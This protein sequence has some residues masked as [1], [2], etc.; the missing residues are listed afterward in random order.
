MLTWR[1]HTRH[2]HGHGRCA[3]A[4]MCVCAC[5]CVLCMHLRMCMRH[6]RM[7]KRRVRMCMCMSM[8]RLPSGSEHE[9][10]AAS[11]C[12]PWPY[13]LEMRASSGAYTRG[14]PASLAAIRAALVLPVPG[15]P[16]KRRAGRCR[17]A[18]RSPPSALVP[19]S[20]AANASGWRSGRMIASSTMP[21]T[22]S[23]PASSSQ[24]APPS[25]G[26]ASFGGGGRVTLAPS[27]CSISSVSASSWG[28]GAANQPAVACAAATG[29]EARLP[30]PRRRLPS[31]P[32]STPPSTLL[33]ADETWDE[34]R[35]EPPAGMPLYPL[36]ESGE[37]GCVH[38]AAFA[39]E[40]RSAASVAQ[41]FL[42]PT[43]SLPTLPACPTCAGFGA[44]SVRP[45]SMSTLRAVAA[46]AR[47]AMLAGSGTSGR[48]A[49]SNRRATR[50][51]VEGRLA[52]IFNTHS[53]ASEGRAV[54][55]LR[56]SPDPPMVPSDPSSDV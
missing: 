51:V 42:R 13:H 32:P 17:C 47:S 30:A 34:T 27:S 28:G 15:G 49:D 38:A 31:P 5:I 11:C 37:P 53:P 14:R 40:A 12:S 26:A 7:C 22:C 33:R 52:H 54:I 1:L 55:V 24:P 36:P 21:R 35:V 44:T 45:A 8:P 23:P 20:T 19:R 2:G 9:K 25:T 29:A 18:S 39:S 4:C 10:S 56:R 43:P 3:C 16:W 48:S 46:A 50:S 41:D 6:L